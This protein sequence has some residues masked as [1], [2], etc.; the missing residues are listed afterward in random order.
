MLLICGIYDHPYGLGN[1]TPSSQ[2][3]RGNEGD[4]SALQ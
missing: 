4:M 1:Q 2:K 3:H